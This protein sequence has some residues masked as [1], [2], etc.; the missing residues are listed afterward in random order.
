MK[1]TLKKISLIDPTDIISKNGQKSITGGRRQW[2]TTY[3]FIFY[4]N[5]SYDTNIIT[6]PHCY[7]PLSDALQ[8]C[9]CD[10]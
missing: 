10:N 8:F 3:C 6:G 2:C 9:D 5:G 7:C 1:K 4:E